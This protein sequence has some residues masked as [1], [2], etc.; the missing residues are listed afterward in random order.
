MKLSIESELGRLRAICIAPP[1]PELDL[2]LPDNIERWTRRDDQMVENP[3]YLLFDDLVL[4]PRLKAEHLQI[5]RVLRA[6]CGAENTLSIPDLIAETLYDAQARDRVISAVLMQEQHVWRN[7][8]SKADEA[9]L[10]GQD[11]RNLMKTLLRGTVMSTRSGL[12]GRR[13]LKWPVPN[14]M[15]ARDLGCVVG[16]RVLLTYAKKAARAREMLLARA[17]FRFHPHWAGT[18]LLDIANDVTGAAIEA[19][20]VLVL[21]PERVLIGV[22]ERTDPAAADAAT[23][24]LHG[25]GFDR[26]YQ[27]EMAQRRATMHLDTVLT[28]IDEGLA[29]VYAPLVL[30]D[31]TLGVTCH[32][33]GSAPVERAGRLLDILAADGLPLDTVCCGGAD[34]VQQA[35]EQWSDG[36]NAFA[37][38]PGKIML[39]GRNQATLRR[40]NE[41]GFEVF[42][43]DDFV[44]NAAFLLA[45]PDRKV[46]VAIEGSEL[47]RGR[48]G[49]RCLTMPLL[50]D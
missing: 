28:L 17:I 30:A 1:G 22:G 16:S 46:V 12:P 21:G 18:E 23:A 25:A 42:T 8:V 31:G 40:L 48:G 36:A 9:L 38:A 45:R 24:L 13:V 35:R 27:V 20:D 43:P 26:V 50:R 2:M 44:R 11:P 33:R 34:P 15:F 4:L 6:C 7:P 10:R 49:P 19:G 37:L 39:Y 5:V 14:L 47:S 3:D 32:V 29:L 41:R